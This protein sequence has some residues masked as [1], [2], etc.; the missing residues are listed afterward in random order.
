MS[1]MP[2]RFLEI[3][4]GNLHAEW[5]RQAR[6]YHRA[7]IK[8]AEARLAYDTAKSELDVVAAETDKEIRDNPSRYGIKKVSEVAVKNAVLMH[9]SHKKATKLV[10]QRKYDVGILQ[11]AVEAL[12]HKKKGLEGSVSLFLSDYFAEPRAPKGARDSI[13]EGVKREVRT[14]GRLKR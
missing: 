4:Q 13:E 1:Q 2:E 8:L 10:N 11:A 7:A 3:D 12:E 5:A 6:L 14:R 9:P